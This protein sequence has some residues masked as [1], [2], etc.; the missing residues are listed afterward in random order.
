MTSDII[1]YPKNSL[2]DNRIKSVDEY[3]EELRCKLEKMRM[4][5]SLLQ[6]L[7]TETNTPNIST[8]NEFS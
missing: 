3:I 2:C 6:E 7:G 5:N 1:Q 4:S 8:T